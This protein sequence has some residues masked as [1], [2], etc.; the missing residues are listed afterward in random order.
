MRWHKRLLVAGVTGALAL[1]ASA[2][3]GGQVRGAGGTPEP[4]A[5]SGG[6]PAATP[7]AQANDS[8]FVY[9]PNLDVVTDWDPATSYSNELVALQNIYEGLTRYDSQERK[10]VPRLATEWTSADGGKE[11]TFKLRQDVTFHSGAKLDAE[12]AK[13]AIER[14]IDKKGGAAYIW[15]SV[16]TIEA[17][18]PSTLKFTLKYP[19]PLDLVASSAYAAYIYDVDAVDKDGKSDAG[20]G[21]YTIDSWQKGKETELTLKAYEDYWGGWKP[22]QYKK[23]AFRV[24]PEITTAWQLLQKGEVNFVQRLNP[25]LFEQAGATPDVQTASSPSFQNLLVLFNTA[26]GPLKDARIRQALQYAIDYDGLVAALKGSGQKASGLVPEGLLGH[27]SGMEPKQDLPKAQELLAEAGYGP[28]NPELK[29]TLTYAQGDEDQKLLV[30]L[31]SSALKG[32]NVTLQAKPMSWGAQ[33]DLGKKQG[34]DI[35]VMYWYPDYPDAYSWFLNV[36]KS[37]DEP[38]FNLSYLKDSGIDAQIDSL[39]ELTATDQLKADQAYQDLQKEIIQEQAAV[40]VP[41]VQKYS[42]ALTADVEGY[43]DNPAYPNVVFFYDLKRKS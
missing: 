18:D 27:V 20:T 35:F 32:V 34:Q 21:P 15:D 40:A 19:T 33:W 39:P 1:T 43:V 6:Q 24:T 8:T 31:L 17:V 5:S 14:T 38:Q 2:C 12:A 9:A 11:W 22:E 28:D 4:A 13:K 41:Y 3:A 23:V 7:A 29:L 10:A 42:R 30:T 16:K 36:F 37:E 26:K 25:Q